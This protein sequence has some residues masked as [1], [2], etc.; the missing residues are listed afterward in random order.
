MDKLYNQLVL[1]RNNLKFKTIYDFQ[2]IGILSE[3]CFNNVIEQKELKDLI[4]NSYN[5]ET[6][7]TDITRLYFCLLNKFKKENLKKE[8]EI[9]RKNLYKWVSEK[10]DRIKKE[11]NIKEKK[12]MLD[13]WIK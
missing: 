3:L 11:N 6:E 2:L 8:K 5:V 4:C 9:F 13:G 7:V 12:G 1:F 10:I